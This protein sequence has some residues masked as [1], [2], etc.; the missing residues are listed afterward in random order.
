MPVRW[1]GGGGLPS[2]FSGERRPAPG[3]CSGGGLNV[4]LPAE[5][6][7]A[8]RGARSGSVS[9]LGK[10][11]RGLSVAFKRWE[12]EDFFNIIFF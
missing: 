8:Y 12:R 1:A 7:S 10:R 3:C 4:V 9:V 6:Q 5:A 2:P 11:F